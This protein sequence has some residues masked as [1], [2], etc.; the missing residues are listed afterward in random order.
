MELDLVF[1]GKDGARSCPS[2]LGWYWIFFLSS[3]MLLDPVPYL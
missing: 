3:G 2:G 1:V